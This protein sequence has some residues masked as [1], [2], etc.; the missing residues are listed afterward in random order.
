MHLYEADRAVA[1]QYV[2][3][4]VQPRIE[5]PAMP[6]GD[7]WSSIE[8]M[9]DAESRVRRGETIDAGSWGV[10][11]YWA[12][13]I[14]LLQI[15]GATGEKGRIDALKSAMIFKRYGSY[16]D[17]RKTVSPRSDVISS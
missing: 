9:L 12:D 3:E 10:D 8:K 14:R 2:D 16:I 15:F 17:I 11:P 7:P 5:M 4:Q 6:E 13:L 1:Q